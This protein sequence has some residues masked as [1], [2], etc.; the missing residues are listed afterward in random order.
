MT[1]KQL[2]NRVKLITVICAAV[3]VALVLWVTVQF[4]T[5]SSLKTAQARYEKEIAA[6]KQQGEGLEAE[7]AILSGSTHIEQAARE[8]LGLTYSDEYKYSVTTE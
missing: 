3:L 6:L 1:E 2:Y 5:R 7:I 8:S 4:I